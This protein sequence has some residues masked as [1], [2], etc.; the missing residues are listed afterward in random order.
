MR[1]IDAKN[2]TET[3]SRLLQDACYR[4]SDDVTTALRRAY[5][6]EESPSPS[7]IK[8]PY[9]RTRGWLSFFWR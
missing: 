2:V 5:E 9:A 7:A 6:S 4:L 8:S 3:I 1:D